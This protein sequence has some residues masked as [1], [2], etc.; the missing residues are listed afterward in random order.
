M[1]Y[2][3]HSKPVFLFSYDHSVCFY[4]A[5]VAV[6]HKEKRPFKFM[7]TNHISI[8]HKSGNDFMQQSNLGAALM[9]DGAGC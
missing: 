4:Q 6:F 1:P 9:T 8:R 7:V 5:N 3:K 2:K